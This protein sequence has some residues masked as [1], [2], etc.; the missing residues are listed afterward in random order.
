MP[1]AGSGLDDC[2][3]RF[4][5]TMQLYS[6]L[7]RTLPTARR[8]QLLVRLAGLTDDAEYDVGEMSGNVPRPR[9]DFGNDH[10]DNGLRPRPLDSL[11]LVSFGP[12]TLRQKKNCFHASLR[13]VLQQPLQTLDF[14]LDPVLDLD[15]QASLRL[16]LAEVSSRNSPGLSSSGLV[17]D[18]GFDQTLYSGNALKR[19][20]GMIARNIFQTTKDP[21][22]AAI[23][24]MAMRKPKLVAGLYK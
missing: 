16:S 4:R 7:C 20:V 22:E 3:L 21:M 19:L 6:Y 14:R 9:S 12:I 13:L 24:Y 17:V 23:F 18:G 5:L 11:R 15:K 2:G 1:I 10:A 8:T